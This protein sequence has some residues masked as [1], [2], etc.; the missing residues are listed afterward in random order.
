VRET[1]FVAV[2][3]APAVAGSTANA[4]EA[5]GSEANGSPAGSEASREHD[6]GGGS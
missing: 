6:R 2:V 5:N 4:S 3:G 1:G